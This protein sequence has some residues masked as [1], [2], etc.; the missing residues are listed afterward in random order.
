MYMHT[1]T[2]APMYGRRL[3]T[4]LW[5]SYNRVPAAAVS[6]FSKGGASLAS[7]TSECSCCR[8]LGHKFSIK[9]ERNCCVVAE[10]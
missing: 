7:E 9:K 5:P 8:T 2:G 1:C 10:S 6:G 3:H 4:K